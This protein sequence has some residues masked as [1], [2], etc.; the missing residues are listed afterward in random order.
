M[1]RVAL[2][3]CGKIADAHM[4]AVRRVEGGEVVAVCDREPL[5]ARQLAERFGVE[6]SF[7]DLGELLASCRPDVVHVTTPPASHGAIARRCLEA[8][9]HVYVEKPATVEPGEIEALIR[10][11]QDRGLLL[12]VGHDQ[13]FGRVAVRLRELVRAGY[14]GGAPVHMESYASYELGDDSYAKSFLSD[15]GHWVHALPGKLLHNVLP[16]AVAR[17]AEHLPDASPRVVARGL[18]SERMRRSGLESTVDE[19]RAVVL[20]RG[21]ATAYLTFSSQIRP[22]LN[23]FRIFGPANGLLLDEATQSLIKLPGRR[24]R[25]H[26]ARILPQLGFAGRYLG[27]FL[28]NTRRLLAAD[29]H[30]K[31]GLKTLIEAF[32]RSIARGGPPPLP[33]R[34][35]VAT[36]RILHAIVEQLADG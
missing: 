3:G 20:A 8:G 36:S 14:L 31:D 18:V 25:S 26:A 6:S 5:M 34:E 21:G 27:S 7:D 9:S 30:F 28:G 10:L 19:L 23:Q 29:L 35:I 24:L 1:L 13:Q 16:H 12:T 22:A 17:L 11:A 32:Y 33:Y 15:R 2:V 4:E